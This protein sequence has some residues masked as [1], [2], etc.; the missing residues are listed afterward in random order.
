M[1]RLQARMILAGGLV[2]VLLATVSGV[3]AEDALSVRLHPSG[4][5]RIIRGGAAE[6][7][8]AMIE[9]NAHGPGWKHAPQESATAQISDL[10]DKA[11]KR[12]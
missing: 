9:L 10:P 6:A 4:T 12:P 3:W 5:V 1:S 8:L 11:G 2:S 7:E